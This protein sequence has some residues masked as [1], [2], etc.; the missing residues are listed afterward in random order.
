MGK[1]RRWLNTA[2]GEM[3]KLRMASWFFNVNNM[4]SAPN[5]LKIEGHVDY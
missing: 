3:S 4:Y 5:S 1:I 2:Q